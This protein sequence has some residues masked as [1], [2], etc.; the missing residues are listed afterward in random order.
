MAALTLDTKRTINKKEKK[1]RHVSFTAVAF[2]VR[3]GASI[4]SGKRRTRL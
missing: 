3:V 4:Y 2:V 1:R